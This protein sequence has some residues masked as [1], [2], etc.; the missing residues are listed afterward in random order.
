MIIFIFFIIFENRLI[1][2]YRICYSNL[3]SHFIKRNSYPLSVISN[4]TLNL[5]RH[6]R[7]MIS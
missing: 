2:T 1:L 7:V 4:V 6:V 5:S 3:R